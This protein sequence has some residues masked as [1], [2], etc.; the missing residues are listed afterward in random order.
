MWCFVLAAL[1]AGR[2]V[3][4]E[5]AP[6]D[7][8][9]LWGAPAMPP[10]PPQA[11][12]Q[13]NQPRKWGP[14]GAPPGNSR[15]TP[16]PRAGAAEA[17]WSADGGAWGA[18][19]LG[20]GVWGSGG[21]D[22]F[23]QTPDDPRR[24]LST[25]DVRDLFGY[26]QRA[27]GFLP[28]RIFGD[29]AGPFP[30]NAWWQNF[31][32]TDDLDNEKNAVFQMPYVIVLGPSD[33]HFM[34]PVLQRCTIA[35]IHCKQ[36]YHKEQGVQ[37][38]L[39][40]PSVR[41][42]AMTWDE[43]SVTIGFGSYGGAP[44]MIVPLVRGSAYMTAEYHD[45]TPKVKSLQRLRP[46][47][48]AAF[49][50]VDGESKRCDGSTPLHGRVFAFDLLEHD[51]T[52]LMF[53]PCAGADKCEIG[54]ICH[55]APFE[56][57][58]N[59][60]L[61][62]AVRVA[63]ANDCT[64]GRGPVHCAGMPHGKDADDYAALLVK[65]AG[66]YPKK[67]K[68]DWSVDGDTGVV[69]WEWEVDTME[70][71]SRQPLLQLAYPVHIPLF[72]KEIR[73]WAEKRAST[74]FR[75]V[76]G[77]AMAIVGDI[78]EMCYSLFPD[79]GFRSRHPI[80]EDMVDRVLDSLRGPGG[81][82]WNSGEP[83]KPDK[84][85]DVPRMYQ[86]GVGDTYFSGKLVSRLARL[87]PIADEVGVSSE[88]YF[89]EMIQ[90]LT[91]RFEVWLVDGAK[92]PFIFDESWG[93]LLSCGCYIDDCWGKC[94][95]HCHNQNSPA[96]TCPE[97]L[98]AGINFG[99]GVYNDHH[100][101]YGYWVY[102]AAVLA[103]YNP[104][105]EMLWRD[106]ILAII[107]DY[108]NPSRQD[109][110]FPVVRHKDWYL[111][112]SWAGGITPGIEGRNQESTSEAYNAYY[113]LYLYGHALE[114]TVGWAN[115]L[116]DLG[117]IL[118]AMEAHGADM[119]WHV[120]H[121]SE[122]YDG[123]QWPHHMV[124]IL[125]EHSA[126]FGT[127]FSQARYAIS[128]IQLMPFTPATEAYLK[129]DWVAEHFPTFLPDCSDDEACQHGW[130]WTVCLEQAILDRYA[131]LDCLDKSIP[132]PSFPTDNDA[133][134]G[135]SLTNSI[136]WIATRPDFNTGYRR[137]RMPIARP[138]PPR[139]ASA[140]GDGAEPALRGKAYQC[141]V[142]DQARCKDG[143]YCS[144]DECCMDGTACASASSTMG[145]DCF[146]PKWY[147]CTSSNPSDW[148]APPPPTKM[149]MKIV[150]VLAGDLLQ[151][152]EQHASASQP[153]QQSAAGMGPQTAVD[154]AGAAQGPPMF[155]QAPA[156]MPE[157]RSVGF[158]AICGVGMLALLGFFAGFMR[159]RCAMRDR[160]LY[161]EMSQFGSRDAMVGF[162]GPQPF[163][164]SHASGFFAAEEGRL[165]VVRDG[166]DFHL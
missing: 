80:A 138:L 90:R 36:D 68:V 116:K 8:R 100:F 37:L 82:R 97:L 136:Y 104:S 81:G 41:P 144:G 126:E 62:G 63:L 105:W 89:S 72:K 166:R 25:Q 13:G 127:W 153:S 54:W 106:K 129:P 160:Q 163:Q 7:L 28:G 143:S 88:P 53:S 120:R 94:E 111:G 83:L 70:G 34:Q 14:P 11:A 165:N 44:L 124:G 69:K 61:R 99:N 6:G 131:A 56:L 121:D 128:G 67:T 22:D 4:A 146:K 117:R 5:E 9:R 30:T 59:Q 109:P 74:P 3:C 75:D 79:V 119:Y 50:G 46:V 96:N 51:S 142:G 35:D 18:D 114:G 148:V 101:H 149:D 118:A 31:A 145:A 125:W 21:N 132:Y 1:A 107:R 2:A 112:F 57:V 10:P 24:P 161:T 98:D 113:A 134:D 48:D 140:E 154:D 47:E 122:V 150:E 87:I 151:R 108:A 52:W 92:T 17:T 78:W 38:S 158:L 20:G 12:I 65:H 45:A 39:V 102:V 110:N 95:P 27:G 135:N 164:A 15:T 66:S 58:A 43:L 103:K 156:E 93:G 91:N 141:H 32:T 139:A 84:D 85:F 23:S 123:T 40:E 130:M 76:R 147:D 71:W 86:L 152:N 60:P 26:A 159:S 49:I 16:V 55:P 29:K 77:G 64:T 137:E 157:V 73:D 133:S 155:A 33:V 115:Q 42:E 19:A 162:T